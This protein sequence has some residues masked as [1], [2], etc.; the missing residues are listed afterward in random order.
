M[1]FRDRR[2]MART[3]RLGAET[4][5]SHLTGKNLCSSLI[6]QGRRISEGTLRGLINTVPVVFHDAFLE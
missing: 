3:D 6:N 2:R 1:T 5:D 4:N